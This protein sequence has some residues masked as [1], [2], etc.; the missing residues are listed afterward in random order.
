MTLLTHLT[1]KDQ[2]FS[3]GVEVENAFQYLKASFMIAPLL[4]HV[5]PSKPFVLE[6]DAFDFAL[7]VVLSQPKENN[8]L[9]PIGFHSHKFS[10]PKIN[11]E[12]HDK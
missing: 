5:G 6:T 8:L 10:P 7:C 12:I 3:W 11:Y 9:H 2:P 1:R 4:I